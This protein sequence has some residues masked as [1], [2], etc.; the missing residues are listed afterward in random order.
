MNNIYTLV[1]HQPHF[2]C[3]QCVRQFLTEL[4]LKITFVQ[5]TGQSLSPPSNGPAPQQP[6]NIPLSLPHSPSTEIYDFASIH[7]LS[8]IDTENGHQTPDSMDEDFIPPFPNLDDFNDYDDYD[9]RDDYSYRDRLETN[10]LEHNSSRNSTPLSISS[11]T[12]HRPK[13]CT[14][15]QKPADNRYLKRRYHHKLNGKSISIS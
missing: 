14:H 9:E 3:S 5:S 15:Q 8:S 12:S 4:D 13:K 2:A 10:M 11:A 6:S 1:P 7:S